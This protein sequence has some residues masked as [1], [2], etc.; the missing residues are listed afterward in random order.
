MAEDFDTGT[1]IEGV[2]E[3]MSAYNE[4]GSD[5]IYRVL[6]E[7]SHAPN[8]AALRENYAHNAAY[9]ATHYDAPVLPPY[10]ALPVL[11]FPVTNEYSVPYDKEGKRFC[12]DE[13]AGLLALLHALLFCDEAEIPSAAERYHRHQNDV[14]ARA[15]AQNIEDAIRAQDFSTEAQTSAEEYHV[16][17]PHGELYELFHAERAFASND[18][19]NAIYY[20][21]AAYEKRKMSTVVCSFLHRAYRRAGRLDRALLFCVL[22]RERAAADFPDDAEAREACLRALTVAHTDM[23]FPPLLMRAVLGENTVKTRL[24]IDLCGELPCFSEEQPC[25]RTGIYNPYGLVHVK[26]HEIATANAVEEPPDYLFFNDAIFDFMKAAVGSRVRIGTDGAPPMLLPLAAKE[27][28]QHITVQAGDMERTMT[29]GRGEFNFYRIEKPVT[30]RSDRPFLIGAPIPLEHSSRRRKFVL[31]IL[32]DGLSWKGIAGEQDVLMPNL[33]HFF[34]KGVIFDNHFSTAE[35]TYPALATIETGVYQHHTQIARPGAAM[36]LDPA[37]VTISERM[38]ALGY[39]AV[40]V[41]GDGQGVYNGA[42]R[43]YDRLIVNRWI[44]RA[45]DGVE[46][47]IRHLQTFDECD[48]FLFLHFSDTH[49][50]NSNI[51]TPAYASA[52]L[53]LAD[54]LQEEGETASVFLKPTP[55]RRCVNRTEIQAVDRHLGMLFDYLTSHYENDEYIVLLYSDHGT[56]VHA[57]SPYLLSEEQTGAALMARG[58]GVPCLGRVDELVSSVD[59]YKILGKLAGYPIDAAYLDGNLPEAFGGERREY[60]VSNSIYPGQTYKICVRTERHAFHFETEEF[61]REDGTIPLERYT[62]HIHERNESYCE[63]FDDALARYFLDIVWEYTKSF[64][65]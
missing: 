60:T 63:V 28:M 46:R 26:S 6:Y 8:E 49:P 15:L 18:I 61:T 40:S 37:Y 24:H 54:V 59:I 65:C 11:L 56:S 20:G 25:Y 53:S 5:E 1:Y 35:Y 57:R 21:E 13:E 9:Y 45:A 51:S 22:A 50:Y 62:Y 33:L 4:S 55:L 43:G 29:F 38:K 48:N 27:D 32:A 36:A 7:L 30:I 12:I 23:Q 52:H 17:C 42:T 16:L 41:Q 44:L 47:T 3:L 64:R 31:N 39:Y 34:S 2:R 14:R 10:D 19:E 58:A